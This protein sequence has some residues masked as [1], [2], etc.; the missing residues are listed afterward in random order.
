MI[1]QARRV[2][3]VA[4]HTKLGR[5]TMALI[6]SIRGVAT[7]VTDSGAAAAQLDALRSAGLEVVVGV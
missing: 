1:G 3:V 2:I 5:V 4:D 6:V 7:V